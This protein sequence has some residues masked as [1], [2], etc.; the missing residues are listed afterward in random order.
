MS[1]EQIKRQAEKLEALIDKLPHSKKGFASSL[2]NQAKTKTTLSSAQQEWVGK[3]I[4]LAQNPPQAKPSKYAKNEVDLEA[5]MHQVVDLFDKAAVTLKRPRV[6]LQPVGHYFELHRLTSASMWPGQIAVRVQRAGATMTYLGRV[7][8]YGKFVSGYPYKDEYPF[9]E[10][11]LVQF[12]QDPAG[13]AAEFGRMTGDCAFCRSKLT[14]ARSTTV[15]YGSTCAKKWQLPYPTMKQLK[16][17][18]VAV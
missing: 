18:G 5:S 7:D 13:T 11:F 17:Q 3:L 6:R 15:G 9:L 4:D 14:D 16:Q 1:N 2:V 10:D 12:A 8:L